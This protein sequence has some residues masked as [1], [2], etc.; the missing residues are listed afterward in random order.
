MTKQD[1]IFFSKKQNWN[2]SEV[3]TE[4]INNVIGIDI[5]T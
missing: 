4:S 2:F 1:I 5:L 3:C